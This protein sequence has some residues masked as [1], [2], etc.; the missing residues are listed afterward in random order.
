MFT[1]RFTCA[2]LVVGIAAASADARPPKR[3][4]PPE[5]LQVAETVV[6]ASV[7]RFLLN[8]RGD[9]DGLLLGDG[10]QVQFPPH[11]TDELIAVVRPGD[12]VSVQGYREYNLPVVKA[13]SITNLGTQRSVVEHPP[14]QPLPRL[15][16]LPF[17]Q[18]LHELS[19]QGT[20]EH[21]LYGKRGEVN[22]ILLS[23]GSVVHFPPPVA[24]QLGTSLQIGQR[25][26]AAGYGVENQYGRALEATSIGAE[27]QTPQAVYG[28]L[29]PRK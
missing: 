18:D 19:A 15:P 25:L 2:V 3:L 29:A 7:S 24:Y 5:Y 10:T 22:G 1:P 4:L 9:I 14:T 8:A 27:G 13:L 17:M 11:M 12:R 26:S 16:R 21:L 20:V 23:D 6:Q 28:P